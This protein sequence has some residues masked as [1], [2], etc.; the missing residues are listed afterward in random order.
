MEEFRAYR[1]LA[2]HLVLIEALPD[3]PGWLEEKAEGAI[4]IA[5]KADACV[6]EDVYKKHSFGA[7]DAMGWFSRKLYVG[8][9]WGL[10][11]PDL[12]PPV[13]A[14]ARALPENKIKYNAYLMLRLIQRRQFSER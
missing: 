7:L 10:P 11:F 3:L 13:L 5:G 2:G 6:L 9:K 14:S 8:A 1:Q 12:F 4:L